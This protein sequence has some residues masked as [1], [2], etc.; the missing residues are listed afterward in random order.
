MSRVSVVTGAASGIGQATARVLA[1]RGDRVIGVDLRG[2]EVSADLSTEEG[3]AGMVEAVTQ[4]SGGVVDGVFAIAGLAQETPP[5]VAV[6]FFGMVGTLE[7]LRPLLLKSSAPRAQGIA[8]L[9]SIMPVD[10]DLV[11]ALTAGDRAAA[12]ARAGE[13]A[14]PGLAAG[15]P[16]YDS[17]KKAFAQW[18]RRNAPTEKWAGASIPLNGIAPGVI[19]T[20]MTAGL[21]ETQ[22][23]TEQLL[24]VAPMPLNGIAPPEAPAQ[25]L[26][27]L[28]SEANTH[29]CGQ[30]IFID[31][32][33]EVLQRG[34]ST[35]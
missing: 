35:W 19:R 28:G 20:P 31:G 29:L 17:T 33:G 12:M 22:Q 4:L 26:A 16:I 2:T 3:L 8:S 10:D 9:A 27:W 32:G 15:G 18:I 25:L 7:G 24:Q 23:A 5:T 14:T 13:I 6:N 34:D 30:I 21:L 1:E 11:A